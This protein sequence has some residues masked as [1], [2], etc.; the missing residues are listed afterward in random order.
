MR[1]NNAP[2]PR[3]SLPRRSVAAWLHS[4][5][6]PNVNIHREVPRLPLIGPPPPCPARRFRRESPMNLQHARPVCRASN[7]FSPSTLLYQHFVVPYYVAHQQRF[8]SSAPALAATEN[9]VPQSPSQVPEATKATIA[10]PRQDSPAQP[11]IRRFYAPVKDKKLADLKR[12]DWKRELVAK[13]RVP[14]AVDG[15]SLPAQALASERYVEE[16]MLR[17][18][19]ACDDGEEYPG[20]LLRPCT[21]PVFIPEQQWPWAARSSGA[22]LDAMSR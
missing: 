17:T 16:L 21:P 4:E 10:E 20:V 19:L 8:S 14:N 13:T 5:G 9:E 3:L 6:I 2:A 12:A 11:R 22:S 15:D 18:R 7:R 1:P